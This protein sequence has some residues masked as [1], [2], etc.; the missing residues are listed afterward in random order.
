MVGILF[1]TLLESSSVLLCFVRPPLTRRHVDED[2]NGRL[3]RAA[4]SGST[5]IFHT[6]SPDPRSDFGS[7]T[8]RADEHDPNWFAALAALRHPGP[9]GPSV[10]NPTR[11]PTTAQPRQGMSRAPRCFLGNS[12]GDRPA[13]PR[14]AAVGRKGILAGTPHC[15]KGSERLPRR[16][17]HVCHQQ[18]C[19]ERRRHQGH[20][21]GGFHTREHV[22]LEKRRQRTET[23]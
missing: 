22:A 23:D 21:E 8:F 15:V 5:G 19:D 1:S 16:Y 14:K 18:T 9:G 20:L 4:L 11:L 12:A 3:P 6:R 7:Q 17:H 10:R 13:E 2:G